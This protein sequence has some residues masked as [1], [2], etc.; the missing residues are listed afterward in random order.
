M[1]S[2]E[3]SLIELASSVTQGCA[4]L[5]AQTGSSQTV[6]SV[7]YQIGTADNITAGRSQAATQILN[8]RACHQISTN[9][10]RLLLFDKLA[11]AVVDKA[12][13]I[14]VSFLCSTADTADFSNVNSLTFAAVAAGALNMNHRSLGGNSIFYSLQIN[15]VAGHRQLLVGY[16]Q[17]NQRAGSFNRRADNSLH[18]VIRSTGYSNQ[19]I[20]CAQ[21]AQQSNCQRMRTADELRTHQCCLSLEQ[22]C[23]NQIQ[24]IAAHITVAVACSRLQVVVGNHVITESR[25]NLFSIVQSCSFQLC[26]MFSNLS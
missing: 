17:V 10:G 16:A 11:V 22:L 21:V 14:R 12:D 20:A 19:L 8:Q 24:S 25:N 1:R 7:L 6:G 26:G 2:Q 9:L 3:K 18:S 4:H 15:M 5:A 13:N 23:V